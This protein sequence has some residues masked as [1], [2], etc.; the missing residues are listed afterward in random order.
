M[1]LFSRFLSL[2]PVLFR[3]VLSGRAVVVILSTEPAWSL[4]SP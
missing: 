3:V 1:S 2:V 4:L